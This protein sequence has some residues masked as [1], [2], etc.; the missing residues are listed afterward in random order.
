MCIRST[1]R[2]DDFVYRHF[3]PLQSLIESDLPTRKDIESVFVAAG[4]QP[5][6][7]K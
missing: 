3:F 6:F 2:E 1:T 7:I 5:Q 4:L